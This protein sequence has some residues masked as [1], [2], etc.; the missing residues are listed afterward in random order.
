MDMILRGVTSIGWEFT[1]ALFGAPEQDAKIL[2]YM[3]EERVLF[4]LCD[5]CRLVLL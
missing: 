3:R 2:I 1:F 5:I 4:R